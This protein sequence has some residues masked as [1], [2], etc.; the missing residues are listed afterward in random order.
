MTAAGTQGKLATQADVAGPKGHMV[1]VHTLTWHVSQ[2][3]LCKVHTRCVSVVVSYLQAQ[4]G[5]PNGG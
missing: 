1:S 3:V 4:P 2:G 5:C